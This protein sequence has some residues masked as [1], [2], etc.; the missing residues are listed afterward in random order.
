[1]LDNLYRK[2]L[3]SNHCSAWQALCPGSVRP[4]DYDPKTKVEAKP[5]FYP[6][7]FLS[8]IKDAGILLAMGGAAIIYITT[9]ISNASMAVPESQLSVLSKRLDTAETAVRWK[10]K[11]VMRAADRKL[12]DPVRQRLPAR[13]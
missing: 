8:F 2:M 9:N 13:L 1:M 6:V 12:S 11:S 10:T 3:A 7:R 4:P 5:S